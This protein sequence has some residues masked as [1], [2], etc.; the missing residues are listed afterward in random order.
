MYQIIVLCRRNIRIRRTIS[1]LLN[2]HRFD[3]IQARHNF[4]V[5]HRFFIVI[6]RA[7]GLFIERAYLRIF[8]QRARI[9]TRI[10]TL[11]NKSRSTSTGEREREREREKY[12]ASLGPAHGT[13]LGAIPVVEYTGDT[14]HSTVNADKRDAL[15]SQWSVI[16]DRA[17]LRRALAASARVRAA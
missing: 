10:Y 3:A 16:I 1:T 17:R 8:M 6:S 5:K 7:S 13:R 2:L 4:S 11:S 14:T 12:F 9:Y 15:N